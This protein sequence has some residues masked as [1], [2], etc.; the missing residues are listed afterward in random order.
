VSSLD[1][2]EGILALVPMWRPL[3]GPTEVQLDCVSYSTRPGQTRPTKGVEGWVH[4]VS[5]ECALP[6]CTIP[7]HTIPHTILCKI[8][9]ARMTSLQE[10]YTQ[11][12]VNSSCH[13]ICTTR[14]QFN[15]STDTPPFVPNKYWFS[16]S[17][18]RST[19]TFFTSLRVGFAGNITNSSFSQL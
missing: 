5:R 7:Y 11:W 19:I 18:L 13:K 16:V 2:G 15:S 9:W 3:W 14:Y 1:A 10:V 8:F 6:Y 4:M 12:D 17:F